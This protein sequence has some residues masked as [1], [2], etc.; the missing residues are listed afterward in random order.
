MIIIFLLAFAA[1]LG[2]FAFGGAKLSKAAKK[3]QVKQYKQ[4]IDEIK[5]EGK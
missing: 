1:M 4:I 3:A 2:L 5:A